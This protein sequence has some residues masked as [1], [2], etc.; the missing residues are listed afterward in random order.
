MDNNEDFN[1]MTA[2][3]QL[4]SEMIRVPTLY[5]KIIKF[6]SHSMVQNLFTPLFSPG[7]QG[8]KNMFQPSVYSFY[9]QALCFLMEL[10]NKETNWLLLFSELVLEKQIILLLAIALYTGSE[11][12]KKKVLFLTG[13]TGFS[14]E[15][16]GSLAKSMAELNKLVIFS[17]SGNN[18]QE[19][20][21]LNTSHLSPMDITPLLSITQEGHLNSILDKFERIANENEN[22]MTS[23]MMEMFQYKMASMSHTLRHMQSSQQAADE[24]STK[25][26]HSLALTSA[27]VS[28]LHQLLHSAQQS[29]EG[30][31][32]EL[33]NINSQL[34]HTQ[35]QAKETH[36]KYAQ[37]LQNT[38]S[39][40]IIINEQN[41]QLEALNLSIKEKQLEINELQSKLSATEEELTQKVQ[42]LQKIETNL[43]EI[44]EKNSGN[45]NFTSF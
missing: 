45:D 31:S 23:A 20:N 34:A 35:Q 43:K 24:R 37:L 25:L 5:S 4:L 39:K 44:Q 30:K 16:L 21:V 3:L 29:L 13:T 18:V 26:Q 36:D 14:A 9:V 40:T 6:L 41:Q 15:S 2:L 19:L 42:Y 22:S 33:K 8:G 27:E 11:P 17:P 10:A 12:I 32:K 28:R 38:K 7:T 1:K